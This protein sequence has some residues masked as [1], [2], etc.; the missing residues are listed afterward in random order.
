MS[1]VKNELIIGDNSCLGDESCF[2]IKSSQDQNNRD[3]DTVIGDGSCK[4]PGACSNF[5]GVSIG[6]N[7]CNCE[8]CCACFATGELPDEI[9]PDSCNVR[10]EC[11]STDA[12][13]GAPSAGP[14]AT[15]STAPPTVTIVTDAPS[16]AVPIE[17]LADCKNAGSTTDIVNCLSGAD[18][19][20]DPNSPQSQALQW[21]LGSSEV[22]NWDGLELSQRYVIGVFMANGATG[23]Q[24]F[25]NQDTLVCGF[26]LGTLICNAEEEI[27]YFD[28]PSEG[29]AGTLPR[30]IGA[31]TALQ[32]L[33]LVNNALTGPIPSEI[34]LLT[35]LTGLRLDINSFSG[36]IPTILG[37]L[38]ALRSLDLGLND[39]TGTITPQLG[40]LASLTSLDL[41]SNQLTGT[42]PVALTQLTNLKYLH[43][44]K[45]N[46]TGQ[47]PSGFCDAPF[48]DWRADGANGKTLSADCMGVPEVQ[49]DCCDYC[50]DESG[51]CFPWNG[52][53]FVPGSFC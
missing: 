25:G 39:L 13:T 53:E 9:P 3:K 11:C 6:S 8:G 41:Q 17:S 20:A 38:T 34:G 45:N 14:T 28:P 51:N 27:Y 2:Q 48:P 26:P 21:I 23:L 15:P 44:E 5:R 43:F 22:D 1:A 46:L 24:S 32:Y 31:L 18:L 19:L 12:P 35:Q 16:A 49:C 30:E 42:I 7:S 37:Q 33:Y 10:G 36:T 40:L 47:V 29:I 4:A 50:F 52:S